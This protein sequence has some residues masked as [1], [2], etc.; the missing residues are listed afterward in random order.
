MLKLHAGYEQVML[1]AGYGAPSLQRMSYICM[2]SYIVPVVF[3]VV[4]CDIARFIC[5]CVLCV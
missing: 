2:L 4:E 5:A 3:F 1:Q